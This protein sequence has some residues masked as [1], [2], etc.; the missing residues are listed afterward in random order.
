ME[1]ELEIVA[2]GGLDNITDLHN[3]GM[4]I[5]EGTANIEKLKG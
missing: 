1:K 5:N 3:K 4:S 2:N